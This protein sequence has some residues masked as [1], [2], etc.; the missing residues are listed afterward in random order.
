MTDGSSPARSADRRAPA[1][2]IVRHYRRNGDWAP[3]ITE[4]MRAHGLDPRDPDAMAPLEQLHLGGHDATRALADWAGLAGGT[5]L[6]IGC[7]IGGPA[8]TLA[9]AFACDVT[10]IDL[11][12]GYCR[13]AGA[14]SR[15]VGLAARTRFA[16]ASAHDLPFAAA[17]FPWVWTQ[18]AAMNIPDKR[19]MYAE[20][21]RVLQPGGR[22]VLHDIVAG[23]GR[24][25]HFPV[26]WASTPDASFLLPARGVHA[27]LRAAGLR[28]RVWEDLSKHAVQ[29]V[30]DAR[31]RMRAGEPEGLGPHLLQGA[32]FLEMRRNLA[33]NL[34]EGRVGVIRAVFEKA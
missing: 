17:S 5:V 9:H 4:L 32:E 15:Q 27:L 2:A 18:H 7:G 26:P 22:L 14:L 33:R 19:A 8:R 10:G 12:H 29:R 30:R 16:C 11:T 25:P 28:E 24:E 1:E 20:I 13:D 3:R 31:A 23:P 21:A 6:D 34:E